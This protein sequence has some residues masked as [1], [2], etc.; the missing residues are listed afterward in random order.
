M[1]TVSP[2]VAMTRLI[3]GLSSPLGGSKTMMSPRFG[4]SNCVDDPGAVAI[5]EGQPVEQVVEVDVLVGV[6]VDQQQFVVVQVRHHAQTVDLEVEDQQ[7]HTK[8]DDRGQEDRLKDFAGGA[9]GRFARALGVLAGCS[10]RVIFNS[11]ASACQV[12]SERVGSRRC[13]H[14]AQR[15]DR[16][17][18][19]RV[20]VPAGLGRKFIHE[21][22][23]RFSRSA[24]VRY[25]DGY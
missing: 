16:L 20:E 14:R 15:R 5:D 6:A 7:S 12:E 13:S 4:G 17:A 2:A 9:G 1:T 10:C 23:S 19:G 3:Y 11:G 22:L 24:A 21:E 8:E 18:A 25:A